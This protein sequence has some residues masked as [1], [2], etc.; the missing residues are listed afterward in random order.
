MAVPEARS[1]NQ[2]VADAQNFLDV[3]TGGTE[4]SEG[5]VGIYRNRAFKSASTD[6]FVLD[7]LLPGTGYEVHIS[8]VKV[9]TGTHHEK[10]IVERPP[11]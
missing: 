4:T 6:T 5:S 7:S 9:R 10:R 1:N 2:R 8:R 11:V 3:E